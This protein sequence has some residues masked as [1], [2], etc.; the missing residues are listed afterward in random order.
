MVEGDCFANSNAPPDPRGTFGAAGTNF[1]EFLKFEA[2]ADV[3]AHTRIA[4][5]AFPGIPLQ[6]SD[7]VRDYSSGRLFILKINAGGNTW[8][9][10]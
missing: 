1:A 7:I 4:Y 6:A 8:D 10:S 2:P 5:D 3:M 9:F